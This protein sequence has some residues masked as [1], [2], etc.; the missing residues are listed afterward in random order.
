MSFR[1]KIEN[2]LK[3]LQERKIAHSILN[4]KRG[5]EKECLRVLGS[6]TLDTSTHPKSLGS[7]LKNPFI[8][9]DDSESLLEFITPPYKKYSE[10]FQQLTDLH[11]FTYKH[12][13]KG[14]LWS[15]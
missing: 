4:M 6:G 10:L 7:N 9:T 8:T 15:G 2:S 5:F 12:L 1:F 11:Q 3:V 13:E 14:L